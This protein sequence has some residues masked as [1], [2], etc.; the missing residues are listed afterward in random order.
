MTRLIL[1]DGAAPAAVLLLLS[2]AAWAS[3]DWSCSW[4]EREGVSETVT[5][6]GY[7]IIL[8]DTFVATRSNTESDKAKVDKNLVYARVG[9]CCLPVSCMINQPALLCMHMC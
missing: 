6:S 4:R 1:P 7:P 8:S 9:V 3:S 2:L 5:A